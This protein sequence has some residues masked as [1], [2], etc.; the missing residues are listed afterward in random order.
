[1]ISAKPIPADLITHSEFA[2]RTTEAP[3]GCVEW[4]GSVNAQGYGRVRTASQGDFQAHRVALAIAGVDIP[5]GFV[6]DHICRNRRC[7]NVAHLDVTTP[8]ENTARGIGPTAAAVFARMRGVCINGHIIAEVGTHRQRGS[9]TCAQCG[10]D[11][12]AAYKLRGAA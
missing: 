11:R 5:Q 9:E 8:R 1:M 6:V 10:R 2:A 7:V 12:V 3:G 4:L